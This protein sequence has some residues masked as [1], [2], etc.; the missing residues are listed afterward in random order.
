M[1]ENRES[2]N[3]IIVIEE[4]WVGLI[5]EVGVIMLS[6]SLI[7][8][9]R[10]EDIRSIYI[11]ECGYMIGDNIGNPIDIR[12]AMVG[13]IFIIFDLEIIILLPWVTTSGE[14]LVNEIWIMCLFLMIVC[15]TYILEK[16][17]KMVVC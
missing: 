7:I 17:S 2:Y 12:Y 5:L 8:N 16:Q 4:M 14:S 1:I 11:V 15:V 13:L 9:R 6:I 10:V 3:E